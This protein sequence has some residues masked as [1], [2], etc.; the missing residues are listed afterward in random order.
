M[1]AADGSQRLRQAISYNHVQ[2]DGM[3]EFFNEGA[4]S[5]T[6]RWEE[7]GILQSQF[8]TNQREYGTVH[9]FILHMERQRWLLAK[10]EIF[11]IM[12][13]AHTQRMFKQLALYS[14]GMFNLVHH[15]HIY[16]FPEAWH[17]GHTGWMGLA[18]GLLHLLWIGIHYQS[19]TS[20]HT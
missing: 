6:C 17:S 19:G 13:A 3:D 7:M 4:D 16:L 1:V 15:T 5:G 8:F 14:T 2:T 11:N 12:L 9:H 18:H 10:T 20:I